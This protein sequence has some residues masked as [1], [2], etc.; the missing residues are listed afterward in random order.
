[1]QTVSDIFLGYLEPSI[2]GHHYYWRQLKDWKGS[3]NVDSAT[4]DELHAFSRNR[5]W[6]LARAHARCGDPIAIA[7]YLDEGKAFDRAVTTFAEHYADQCER[8]Y[9]A[10]VAEIQS[11]RLEVTELE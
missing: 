6:T 2:H 5:G 4:R 3:A 10:F 8:D 7:G 9:E 1:M 11:N